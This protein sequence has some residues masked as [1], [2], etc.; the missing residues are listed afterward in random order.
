MDNDTNK[1]LTQVAQLNIKH[2][3]E[4]INNL[5]EHLKNILSFQI[6]SENLYYELSDKLKKYLSEIINIDKKLNNIIEDKEYGLDYE[7]RVLLLDVKNDITNLRTDLASLV[8]EYGYLTLS[9]IFEI[10]LPI[11]VYSE[12]K[13]E[14]NKKINFIEKYYQA[15]S[16]SKISITS[17][18]QVNMKLKELSL[19]K[20][21]TKDKD[22]EKEIEPSEKLNLN[23]IYELNKACIEIE[24]DDTCYIIYG[25]F[26]ED[27][28]NLVYNDPLFEDKYKKVVGEFIKIQKFDS[29]NSSSST[30]SS[31]LNSKIFCKEYLSQYSVK[32]FIIKDYKEIAS[33]IDKNFK[34]FNKISK[35]NILELLNNFI[36]EDLYQ[37]RNT[38]IL[39]LINDTDSDDISEFDEIENEITLYK[40]DSKIP[41]F[42]LL[43]DVKNKNLSEL[44]NS[45]LSDD[46]SINKDYKI[47]DELKNMVPKLNKATA[48]RYSISSLMKN[49]DSK[50]EIKSFNKIVYNSKK[51]LNANVLID[52]L[53]TNM[54]KP[55]E[56][57]NFKKSIH[58]ILRRRIFAKETNEN[59]QIKSK[60]ELSYDMK[61][62]LLEIPDKS[63]QKV[64]E[65]IKELKTSKDNAKAESYIEGFF[66]IPFNNYVKEDIF[67]SCDKYNE[68]IQNYIKKIN[69]IITESDSQT[70][71]EILIKSSDP[72]EK[73]LE[74]TK[75]LSQEIK[76]NVELL[77]KEKQKLLQL[78]T[79]YL[80]KVDSILESAI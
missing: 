74:K 28:I 10:I 62:D 27:S 68:Q 44:E 36:D 59:K 16:I 24:I 40:N 76:S 67:L 77:I 42:L 15:K 49:F 64:Q 19:T 79:N 55:D 4:I 37:K 23:L 53:K 8:Y 30:N 54:L 57:Q 1:L 71:S 13:N 65:K 48:T 41:N 66:K 2:I 56:F 50:N 45:T 69:L 61:L 51:L 35:Q 7:N 18:K 78:K 17:F 21:K 14:I 33:D 3:K 58:N 20:L 52:F 46:E 6:I 47:Q 39:L 38:I 60:E 73:I 5:N 80:D 63:K 11:D 34:I 22:K 26:K 12:Y 32:D 9:G 29:S 43:P 70:K 72:N 31:I 75:L 25:F